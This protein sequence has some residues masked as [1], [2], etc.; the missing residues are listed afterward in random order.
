M[1]ETARKYFVI[2]L[3]AGILVYVAFIPAL[4]LTGGFEIKLLGLNIIH[5]S[6]IFETLIPLVFL[7]IFIAID[8]KD[9]IL[10]IVTV[11]VC[12]G[13][14]EISLRIWNPMIAR[15][16][17]SQIHRASDIYDW[18]LIPNSSAV[19][20]QMGEEFKINSEGIR[21]NEN[22]LKKLPEVKRIICIGGSFTFGVGVDIEETYT[23]YIKKILEEKGSK[24]EASNYG[25]I[26]YNMWQYVETLKRKVLKFNPDIVTIALSPDD[27]AGS[28]P[29][30][31]NPDWKGSNPFAGG[32]HGLA[33]KS[34]FFSFINNVE[35]IVE[36]KIRYKRG[37]GYLKGIEER[38]AE[39][40]PENTDDYTVQIMYGNI[41]ERH[42][43]NFKTALNKIKN[44]VDKAGIKL[45]L[46]Q[47]P[48][49]AQ[50]NNPP[51]QKVNQF[52]KQVCKDV[53][54]EYFDLTP[55]VE[56]KDNLPSLYL[57]PIDAHASVDGHRVM[58]EAIAGRLVE[59]G[60]LK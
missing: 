42:R 17:S 14:F 59:L 31:D 22:E 48:D 19:G 27:L 51:T 4:I 28:L 3:N 54:V 44:I 13:F 10:L 24:V 41:K 11:V 15:P 39:F 60:Y 6:R 23:K 1:K 30:Y 21:G 58:A 49:A 8:W 35:A 12:I 38:Q 16:V 9:F 57:F 50:L 56:K 55:V 7:R 25:V 18:E 52:Y 32:D 2:L 20:G 47:I 29:P 45:L 34:Y 53:G 5:F 36:S 37:L 43:K 46:F 26:G 33:G 40:T